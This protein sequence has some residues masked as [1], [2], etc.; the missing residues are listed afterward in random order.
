MT[1]KALEREGTNAFD[2]AAML[3][4]YC[5]FRIICALVAV[6]WF[7]RLDHFILAVIAAEVAF[8]NFRLRRFAFRIARGEI[9]DA[10]PRPFLILEAKTAIL[11]L[12]LAFILWLRG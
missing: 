6:A 11:W 4:G 2:P 12:G 10:Q 1:D 8:A 7:L 9:E 3:R 5:V